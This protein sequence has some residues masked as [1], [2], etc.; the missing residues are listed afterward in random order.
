MSNLVFQRLSK[1]RQRNV[2]VAAAI[3]SK[4]STRRSRDSPMYRSSASIPCSCWTSPPLRC[5]PAGRYPRPSSR[6]IYAGTR[7]LAPM[8]SCFSVPHTLSL[9]L[10]AS[11]VRTPPAWVG[12]RHAGVAKCSRNNLQQQPTGLRGRLPVSV[13]SIWTARQVLVDSSVRAVSCPKLPWLPVRVHGTCFVLSL[14][15]HRSLPCSSSSRAHRVGTESERLSRGSVYR[16]DELLYPQPCVPQERG[17]ALL[18]AL[19][20][21]WVPHNLTRTTYYI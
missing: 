5:L 18:L 6:H 8:T 21:G 13:L 7:S 14:A 20:S 17:S 10:S 1:Q 15:L 19:L 11:P 12:S 16:Y 3:T 9:S 4:C 2:H